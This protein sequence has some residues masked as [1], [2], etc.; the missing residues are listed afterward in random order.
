MKTSDIST[1]P[2]RPPH[3]NTLTVTNLMT[4]YN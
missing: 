4:E 3:V 1:T 2:G